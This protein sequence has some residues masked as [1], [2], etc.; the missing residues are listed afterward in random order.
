MAE[1]KIKNFA[2]L[3]GNANNPE[4]K[5]FDENTSSWVEV[6]LPFIVFSKLQSPLTVNNLQKTHKSYKRCDLIFL[7]EPSEGEESG[8]LVVYYRIKTNMKIQLIYKSEKSEN[9]QYDLMVFSYKNTWHLKNAPPVIFILVYIPDMGQVKKA[10]EEI[11][12]CYKKWKDWSNNG[13]VF[14]LGNLQDNG[15]WNSDLE[16]HVYGDCPTT[17]KCYGNA[18][19]VFQCKCEPTGEQQ[20]RTIFLIPKDEVCEHPQNPPEW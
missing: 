11:T 14:L 2:R 19:D 3:S 20:D 16:L 6:N 5:E 15:E 9:T 10:G 8:S 18:S 17:L 7:I 1:Q 12:K 4:K 13:P